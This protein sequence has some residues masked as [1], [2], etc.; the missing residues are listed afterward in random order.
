MRDESE[1]LLPPDELPISMKEEVE[2]EI[3][4]LL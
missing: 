2:K 3:S 1:R 4:E